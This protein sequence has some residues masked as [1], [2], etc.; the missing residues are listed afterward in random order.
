MSSED[1]MGFL[2]T[3][4][5]K[6][7]TFL[8]SSG[9]MSRAVRSYNY[10]YGRM[11]RNTDGSRLGIA[12]DQGELMTM[13]T[14]H[15]RNLLLH[16]L[17]IITQQRL[18]FDCQS[19]S[20]DVNAR[21]ATIV[22][23]MVLE[24]QFY[25]KQVDKHIHRAAELGLFMGTSFLS[26]EWNPYDKLLGIDGEGT[27]IYMGAPKIKAH[28]IFDVVWSPWKDDDNDQQWCQVREMANRWDLIALFPEHADQIRALPRIS[29][30]QL[31]DPFYRPE[32]DHVFLYKVYHKETPALPAGRMMWY[33]EKDVV[34]FDG[35]NPYIHPTQPT[36]NGGLPI[37][38]F[39]PAIQYATYAGHTIAFDLMP[40]QE[41][42][43]ILDSSIITNQQNFAVQN[44]AI[45]KESS[46]T[47]ADITGGAKLIEY[48][49]VDGVP[50][51]GKPEVLQ[52]CATPGE[53]FTHR[54]TII[55]NMEQISGINSVLRGQPQASL[56]SGTAL[57]LVATQA[58]SFNSTLEGNFT[59]FA[60]QTAHFLLHVIAKFQKTEDL[61]A[62]MG[63]GKSNEIRSFKGDDLAPIRKVKVTV[64]NP[65]AKTTAGKLEIA[66]KLL[67]AGLIKTPQEF[68]EVLQTGN[69][70]NAIEN[71]TA[72]LSY[73][74]WENEAFLRGE[75]PPVLAT[76]NHP[77]HVLEHRGQT[78]KPE[79]RQNPQYHTQLL[80]HM[81]EH[82]DQIDTMAVNNPTLFAICTGQP[83]PMPQPAPA[84]GVGSEGQAQS[85]GVS[86][87][88]G[89]S[90]VG[91]SPIQ[92]PGEP[93]SQEQ[94]AI[95]AMQS[96]AS[97]V[98]QSE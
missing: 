44:I 70:Q 87:I 12:G 32:D 7:R 65:L 22:G 15:F 40:L 80:N 28:S 35:N 90:E 79:V 1:L 47:T 46:V 6:T 63:K 98:K 10:A 73:I 11:W 13:S 74:K 77:L 49:V 60:E 69:L 50:G 62:L 8:N 16:T 29:D 88:K 71:D 24:Q 5:D 2:S 86:E 85:P 43:N 14:N 19:E 21:N 57:A 68:L 36:P 51:G 30:I 84:T 92:A 56:I 34:L 91:K 96:A 39:R 58:N 94:L 81:K 66:E 72:E 37:F 89:V 9:I 26:V 53:V 3:I 33:C 23:N 67:N 64:G 41:A 18:V 48:S 97:K 61:I 59:K 78:F 27:P 52:L 76:D 95:Q 4:S 25:E 31:Y 82:L 55:R 42:L 75:N 83:I 54:E 38:C 93:G 17:A 45:P 20:T